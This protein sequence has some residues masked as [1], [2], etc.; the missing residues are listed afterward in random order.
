MMNISKK[1]CLLD[2]NVLIYA[3][4][5]ASPFHKR[6]VEIVQEIVS[7]GNGVLAQQ[8]IVE[9][10]NVLH[11]EYRASYRS[12]TEA[13]EHLLLDIPVIHP[14]TETIPL[15]LQLLNKLQPPVKR[16]FD[17]YLSATM[18]SNGISII[19]TANG[20]DFEG[21]EGITVINPWKKA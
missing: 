2:S 11:R 3:H 4:D 12:I 5:K 6:A 16:F 18:L 9:F 17:L 13:L 10:S 1:R 20:K 21:I 14:T 19:L 7:E 15:Y 8:N